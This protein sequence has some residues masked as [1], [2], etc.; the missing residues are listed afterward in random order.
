MEAV[1]A[2][3]WTRDQSGCF[4]PHKV[5]VRLGLD[6]ARN[7]ADIELKRRARPPRA[8]DAAQGL[9]LLKAITFAAAWASA[10]MLYDWD[11]GNASYW[12]WAPKAH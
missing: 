5:L 6:G 9:D 3:N 7:E 12:L 2:K 10:E 8:A 4:A 11:H 1:I